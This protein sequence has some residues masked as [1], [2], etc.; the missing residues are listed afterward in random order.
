MNI[1]LLTPGTGN[2]YC[3]SCL[4]DH[5]MVRALRTA[6]HDARLVPM[7]LPQVFDIPAADTS[8]GEIFFGGINVYL[9]Q[10]IGMFRRTPRW[11]DRWFDAPVLLRSIAGLAGMTSA[12]EM[13][14]ITVSM[15][16]GEHGRQAKELDRLIDWI[17]QTQ[18]PDVICLNNAL[19]LGLARRLKERLA[20]PVVCTLHGED[21][22]IDTL[23]SPYS[24]Q[25]WDE[26]G[27]RMVDA[28]ALIAVSHY[29]ADVMRNRVGLELRLPD[30][31]YN[32]I[33]VTCFQP[34]PAPPE[35]PTIGYLARLHPDKGLGQLADAYI[36]LKC[37]DATNNVRL[38]VI[39][40]QTPADRRF[41]QKIRTRLER[42]HVADDV[43]WHINVSHGEKAALLHS[44]SVLSVP[45]TYGEAFGLYLLEAWACG[46]PVVQPRSGAFTELLEMTSAGILCK[47]DDTESLADALFQALTNCEESAQMGRRG[48]IAVLEQFTDEQMAD[49]FLSVLRR[50]VEG[51]GRCN[52]L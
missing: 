49:R 13:G 3:G 46:V 32:G 25:T 28:D 43:R 44:L 4:R 7:Y 9:Q 45:A 15:L 20:I 26:L 29:Y 23:P 8:S 47:P 11:F 27:R 50:V 14:Q 16:K 1:L 19:L 51:G 2:F 18:E 21:A 34:A 31:V 36:N 6:G 5:A 48:R 24:E 40:T 30:V 17:Q 52:G 41:V 10:K 12:C 33:A 39:G 22:F 37:R 38:C 35:H 42:A